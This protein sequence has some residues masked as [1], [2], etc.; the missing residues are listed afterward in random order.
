MNKPQVIILGAGKPYSGE[1]PS[2]LMQAPG[3][4]RRVLDWVMEAFSEI[5]G[6]EFHFVGGYRL[7]DIIAKYPNIYFSVNADWKT[8]SATGSLLS[9]PIES[10]RDA[11]IC[12]S[13]TVFS[14]EIV[15]DLAGSTANVALCIDRHWR[16]RYESRSHEDIASAEKVLVR[17]DGKVEVGRAID[18]E[19][20]DGELIGVFKFSGLAITTIKALA[21][22]EG[23]ERFGQLDMP[24]LIKRLV[25]AGLDID[26]IENRGRWAELNAPQDLA[27]FVLGTK[28]ETL[29][30]LRPLVQ[31]S[32]IGEQVC[33]TAGHWQTEKQVVLDAVQ[34]KFGHTAVIVR[35]SAHSEDGWAASNA[36]SYES[37]LNVPA[38][39][40]DKIGA[41]IE[42]VIASYGK[43]LLT[44]QILV[45]KMLHDVALS[46]VA[47]TRTLTHRAPY[48]VLNFDDSSSRTDSVTGGGRQDLRTLF[49]CRSR[50]GSVKR[51]DP[52]IDRVVTA[53][54]E[55][56][57]LVGHSS[58]DIEFAMDTEGVVHILQLRPLAARHKASHVSDENVDLAL[59]EASRWFD[60]AGMR[61]SRLLGNR[62][63][64]GV[65][66]DWNPAE[67]VGTK[68]RNLALSLYRQ[69]ITDDTWAQQRAEYGYR[70][71]RPCPLIVSFAGH[72]YVD[73]RAS[74]NSFVPA[75]LDKNL[76]ERLV[77]H[78]LNHLAR[79]PEL[80]DKVEFDIAFTCL[81][82]DFDSLA[83]DRLTT[84]GF[85]A[86][87]VG[88]LKQALLDITNKGIARVE[89]DYAALEVLEERY[90]ALL[91]QPMVPLDHAFELLADCRRF[92][93]LA[94]AHLA[95]SAFVAMALLRSLERVG[96]TTPQDTSAFLGSLETVTGMFEKDGMRVHA[97]TLSLDEFVAR[98]G[99]LRP[100]TYEI[101]SDAYS[102]DPERY[103]KP[104]IRPHGGPTN[105]FSW[106]PTM[107]ERIQDQL[108]ALGIHTEIDGFEHFIRRAIAGRE[109]SKFLFTRNLS[110]ALS[111]IGQI[112]H[113]DREAL[114]HVDVSDLNKLRVGA[115]PANVAAW[116][117]A[118]AEEGTTEYELRCA[119]ELPPL[120]TRVE[121]FEAFER[122]SSEPNFVGQG[123]LSAEI[124][125]MA[126]GEAIT[127][128]PL[129]GKIV[130]I[131]RADPGY[132]WLFA[133]DIGGLVTQYGGA[134][135]HMAIRSAEVGLPAAIGVG[136]SCFERLCA[137]R[138]IL[139]DCAARKIE[140]QA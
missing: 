11:Y 7:Q 49:V 41:A 43:S 96:I 10:G 118:R 25:A 106:S 20:A 119:I 32:V 50:L 104:M 120:I 108:Q 33:F 69:L 140:V 59:K 48:Y 19:S 21:V 45:Q 136:E 133:H 76:A 30:R 64:F 105:T 92:G 13:D 53:I 139:L 38:S 18:A 114:S 95:R 60:G 35:S 99:H 127:T 72:P 110:A 89:T 63:I 137:A 109:Y 71:V 128:A 75:A 86:I 113:L 66:T 67:I 40:P 15:N 1:H 83:A 79:R 70:D 23:E 126:D 46:G 9:A 73:I 8:S 39:E 5:A 52:R 121:D 44:D 116:L 85:S 101:T 65:M 115:H 29:E 91:A 17:E 130:V 90:D 82:F 135:S 27:H 93:T 6:A 14:P 16:D 87:D 103:L 80:H 2:A 84:S 123:R 34:A 42:R 131:P 112:G 47:F 37:I 3:N 56:E 51:L 12:Y 4:S 117:S 55:L 36:G 107:R 100:G 22:E 68:P 61:G 81:T 31:T 24:G 77:D 57:D 102:D 111:A 78:Y 58:L 26:V 129:A 62:P 28:A 138:M 97:G 132:D 54:L 94:F 124:V 74:F 122:P 88:T 125:V 98:Y 134:N